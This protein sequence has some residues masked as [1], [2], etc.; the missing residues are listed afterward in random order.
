MSCG[1]ENFSAAASIANSI[2]NKQLKE[3]NSDDNYNH[4]EKKRRIDEF[5][6]SMP[7]N[8]KLSELKF[9]EEINNKNSGESMFYENHAKQNELLSK[10]RQ[11]GI[12][13][14]IGGK[15]LMDMEESDCK[16]MKVKL[17]DGTIRNVKMHEDDFDLKNVI[18][19]F[20][21]V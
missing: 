15:N 9:N 19:N 21:N 11:N 2:I 16:T 18:E 10:Q 4:M 3:V 7:N 6:N 12:R 13:F 17:L 14:S 1:L 8:G 5:G 20:E